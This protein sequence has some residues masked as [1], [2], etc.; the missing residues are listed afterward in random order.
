MVNRAFSNY[1]IS[2]TPLIFLPVPVVDAAQHLHSQQL[3]IVNIESI[4]SQPRSD[5]AGSLISTRLLLRSPLLPLPL[6]KLLIYVAQKSHAW[7]SSIF[8][9][10]FADH[11]KSELHA[12]TF[13]HAVLREPEDVTVTDFLES[14]SD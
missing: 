6:L 2:A 11:R 13:I 12:S 8:L 4:P 3:N 9:L 1:K 7:R 5:D 14:L 10:K